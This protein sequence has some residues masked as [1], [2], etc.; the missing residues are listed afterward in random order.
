MHAI[1]PNCQ[2]NVS[3]GINQETSSKLRVL[4]P[5]LANQTDGLVSKLF[6]LPRAQIFFPKLDVVHTS[7]CSLG[8]FVKQNATAGKLIARELAA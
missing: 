8:N 6:Q 4:G 5:K 1:R 2:R 3:T 7:A